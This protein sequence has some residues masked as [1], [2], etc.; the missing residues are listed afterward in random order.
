MTR[1]T[2]SLGPALALA[3]VASAALLGV[4][5]ARAAQWLH[6]DEPDFELYGD[7]TPKQVAEAVRNMQVYRYARDTVLPRLKGSDVVRPRVFVLSGSTFEQ[8]ARSRRNV[9]GYVSGRDF[10]VDIVIDTSSEDWTGTSSIVQHELT[11][12]YLHNAADFALQPWFDEGLAEYL[13]TITVERGQL[14]VGLPAGGRWLNLHSMPWMPLRQ[15]LGA[16]R[17]SATYTSHTAAPAFYAQSWALV[18]YVNTVKGEDAKRIGLMLGY[19]DRGGSLDDAIRASFGD[20]FDAFE[21]RVRKYA[22]SRSLGYQQQP[23]PPLPDL[24]DKVVRIDEQ[25]GLTEL[26]LMGVRTGRE[27]DPDVKKLVD[28]LAADTSNLGAA[29]AQAFIARAAGDWTAATD[30]LARCAGGAADDETLV[31]CGDAWLAPYFR[32][33]ADAT[34]ADDR[35]RDAAKQAAELYARAWRANPD[36]FEAVNSMMLAHTVHREHGAE[37]EA[38]MRGAVERHPRSAILRM[39]Y[40]QLQAANGDLPG[41][42]RSLERVLTDT[43]DPDMR[44]RVIRNLRG[45]ENEIARREAQSPRAP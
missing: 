5:A 12:Y 28:R 43:N 26:A 41:A 21:E 16:S 6:Y 27:G 45:V 19:Q 38:Q 25:R 13:S 24:R 37:I 36:N 2:R 17:R 3:W 9:A 23:A 42:R 18:H 34:G 29:A 44:M 7:A 22:R 20:G 32:G 4:P 30:A 40:A 10:S 8:Y 35:T 33:R 15:V 39:H 11:H 31:L 14:R 1:R